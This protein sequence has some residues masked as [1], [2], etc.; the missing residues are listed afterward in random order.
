MRAVVLVDGGQKASVRVKW[1]PEG[2]CGG[3]YGGRKASVLVAT[4]G[5]KQCA[6]DMEDPKAGV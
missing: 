4:G 6:S 1:G 2:G 3:G 5:V